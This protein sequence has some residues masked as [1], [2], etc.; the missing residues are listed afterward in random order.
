MMFDHNLEHQRID[1]RIEFPSEGL[2]QVERLA[3]RVLKYLPLAEVTR[4]RDVIQLDDGGEEGIIVLVT[5]EKVELRLPTVEWTQGAYGPAYA[6]CFW[7]RV[8][9]FI[10]SITKGDA[11]TSQIWMASCCRSMQSS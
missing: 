10:E 3:L 4:T 6:S 5:A 9:R 11:R 1:P 8:N 7:K 2:R